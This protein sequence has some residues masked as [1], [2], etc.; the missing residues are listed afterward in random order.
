M[1]HPICRPQWNDPIPWNR[2]CPAYILCTSEANFG[3][4]RSPNF[5]AH[6]VLPIELQHFAP[7]GHLKTSPLHCFIC[8]ESP[9]MQLR[10]QGVLLQQGGQPLQSDQWMLLLPFLQNILKNV[11]DTDSLKKKDWYMIRIPEKRGIQT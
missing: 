3:H 6:L 10:V 2:Q 9:A 1:L 11:E 4:L 7:I 5:L 8:K